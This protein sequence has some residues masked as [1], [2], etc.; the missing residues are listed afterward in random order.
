MNFRLP[1]LQILLRTLAA[2]ALVPCAGFS[3]DPP[4]PE[5]LVEKPRLAPRPLPGTVA[6]QD[7]DKSRAAETP[8]VPFIPMPEP[9]PPADGAE[10]APTPIDM[11][12]ARILVVRRRGTFKIPPAAAPKA[13]EPAASGTGEASAPVAV[14]EPLAEGKFRIIPRA[15]VPPTSPAPPIKP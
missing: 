14:Q 3:A 15:L 11:D 8:V 6:A 9:A 1:L 2:A 5:I 10:A 13:A 4:R 7:K 12:R